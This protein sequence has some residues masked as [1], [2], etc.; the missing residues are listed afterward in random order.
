MGIHN[1]I[2]SSKY[3]KLLIVGNFPQLVTTYI[4][5]VFVILLALYHLVLEV[6]R[7]IF[8]RLKYLKNK[9]N[10]IHLPLY[11]LSLIFVCV[12]FDKCGCPT[13]WQWQIGIFVIFLGWIR[14]IIY[15][16]KFP[17][18]GLYVIIFYEIVVTFLKLVAFA[19][20]LVVAFAIILFMMFNNP[21]ANEVSY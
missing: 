18:T 15:A 14:L 4:L 16:S 17:Y 21:M 20:L 19:I 5:A 9:T 2:P 13:K 11:I 12:F 8:Y 3:V 6:F 10:Y 1:I 7:M